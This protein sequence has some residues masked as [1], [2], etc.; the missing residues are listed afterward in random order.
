MTMAEL[1]RELVYE[2]IEPTEHEHTTDPEENP[3]TD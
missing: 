2:E 1:L 3:N